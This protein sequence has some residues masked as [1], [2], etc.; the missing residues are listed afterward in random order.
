M[1]G[2]PTDQ[3]GYTTHLRWAFVIIGTCFLV[4]AGRLFYLQVLYG[5]RFEA[6]A[7]VSHVAHKRLQ[8]VRGRIT[9]RNGIVL[10]T[11]VQVSDLMVAPRYVD[12]PN[13]EI[14]RLLGL[15][16][17]T[18]KEADALLRKVLRLRRSKQG[19]GYKVAKGWLVS[20]RCPHDLGRMVYDKESR[21]MVCP[22]C[23]RSYVNEKAV[24]EAHLHELPGF[25]IRER[26]VRYYP[27][28][29]LAAHVVGFVG[30]VSREEIERSAGRFRPGDV[31]GRT[32][33]EKAFDKF[34]R[35][36]AGEEVFVRMADGKRLETSS[37]PPPFDQLKSTLPVNG[38]DLKLSIDI[39]LQKVAAGAMRQ[40]RSGAIVVMDAHTGEVLVL[41]S[42]PSFDPTPVALKSRESEPQNPALSPY[43]NKAVTAYPPGSVFKVVTALAGLNEGTITPDFTVDCTGRM[44]YKGRYFRCYKR[45]GHGPVALREAIAVSC[46]IY[47]YVLADM[48]GLDVI[49][50]YARDYFGLGE[51]TGIEIGKRRGLIPTVRWYRR[52]SESG[53]Q[54]GNALNVAVGQGDVKVTVLQVARALAALVNG[55]K[56]LRPVLVL[57]KAFPDG[58]VQKTHLPQVLRHW[59]VN[60]R[61]MEIIESGLFD[62]VNTDGGT[63]YDA[64]I[65]ELPFAG[66]TG[67]AQAPESR[68]GVT[69]QRDKQWLR[70]D[71]A[72]FAGYAPAERPRIVVVVMVE[73]GGAGGAVA[74]P[75]ARHVIRA[76][77][78]DHAEEFADLFRGI[79]SVPPLEVLPQ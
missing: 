39:H 8:P 66:K 50:H 67:T 7:R 45:S 52:H 60:Q 30:E 37:L 79:E 72:W 77:Y 13:Q 55:G 65:A 3:V 48:L 56:L 76:Y 36:K 71:H 21:K 78:A 20:N 64:R 61:L 22:V 51:Y 10:A 49:A 26:L 9:D 23:G 31:V 18:K 33:I 73:H 5:N 29:R 2:L 42:H 6:L 12:G 58:R 40:H 19:F 59:D 41:Y 69:R 17:L 75:V 62:A 11:Q 68:P 74:A 46:D 28:G 43:L 24:V 34:L 1:E 44:Q 32:G 63:A 47:F 54:P 14:A 16:I 27:S 4:L 38:G 25:S 15:G 35:G 70:Q 57:E 53:F